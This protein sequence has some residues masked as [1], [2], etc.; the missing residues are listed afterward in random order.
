VEKVA[1]KLNTSIE[2]AAYSIFSIANSNM[3]DAISVVTTKNGHDVRDFSLF[4]LGGAGATHAAFLA[5]ALGI[6]EVIVPPFASSFCAWS[7]FTLDIGRDYLR[8]CVAPAETVNLD[9]INQLYHDM[10]E[11]AL[12]EFVAF[13]V[14]HAELEIKKSMEF[15]YKSQFHD[16]EVYDVP[17]KELTLA[18]FESVIES[19]HKRYEELHAYSLRFYSVELRSLGIT[20]KVQKRDNI[21]IKELPVG[22]EDVSEALK[23]Q[24]VCLFDG[25]HVQTPVYDSEKLKANNSITGPAIIEVPTTTVVIPQSWN[26]KVDK[27]GNYIMRRA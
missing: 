27:Y 26:C 3:A 23:R 17:N 4:A 25:K 16:V 11:Q 13:G 2:Q 10:V 20:V 1:G 5:E 15:R 9:T 12:E 18:D 24:R 8:S 14:G 21:N 19:F 22:T 6:P 7:M